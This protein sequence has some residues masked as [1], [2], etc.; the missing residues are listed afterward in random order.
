MTKLGNDIASLTCQDELEKNGCFVYA[1]QEDIPLTRETVIRT[2]DH[3]YV[4]SLYDS[5]S[6]FS[7]DDDLPLSA[8]AHC[9][10]GIL[11]EHNEKFID[12]VFRRAPQVKWI[13]N[14]TFPNANLLRCV[15]GVVLN[16]SEFKVL[17]KGYTLELMGLMITS[18][19]VRWLIVLMD[20]SDIM[21]YTSKA[22][23]TFAGLDN[24]GANEE[25][26]NDFLL[27]LL[28]KLQEKEIEE[29]IL[30]FELKLR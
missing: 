10:Y 29:A 20:N 16:E 28:E 3:E 27:A 14:H 30:D 15:H 19:G 23:D 25:K 18:I 5:V 22:D 8:I 21:Y 9:D 11:N 4:L 6:D 1:K 13:F 17:N 7:L 2:I 24:Y 12:G 26:R